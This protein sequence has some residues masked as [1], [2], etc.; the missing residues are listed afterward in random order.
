MASRRKEDLHAV[1]IEAV[2]FAFSEWDL[3]YP[4]FPRPFLTATFRP[5]KE[6]DELYAQGRTKKGAKV[7]NAKAGQ[8]AHNYLPSFAF[9]VAFKKEDGTL[10]WNNALF[11]LL[12]AIIKERFKD[13]ITWG[14]DF[15]SIKD[16]PHFELKNWKR[17]KGEIV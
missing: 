15:K 8:S 10:D 6:Q 7:T 11:G 13:V 3:R 17:H 14:G 2:D 9:D 4:S 1:L 5:N 16:R 12:A